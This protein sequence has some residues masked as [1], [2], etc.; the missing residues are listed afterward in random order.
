LAL[1]FRNGRANDIMNMHLADGLTELLLKSR[2]TRE[3]I[4]TYSAG[5][6]AS[7][8]NVDEY[9]AILILNAAKSN[10]SER[11]PSALKS[12]WVSRNLLAY[13]WI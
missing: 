1:T 8:L 4:L 12:K 5:E 2:L 3:E 13:H 7:L 11:S 9:V 6:L 10:F